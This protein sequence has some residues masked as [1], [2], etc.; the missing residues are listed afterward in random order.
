MFEILT[1]QQIAEEFAA[2]INGSEIGKELTNDLEKEAKNLGLVVIFG[3]SDDLAELRGA[4]NDEVSVYDG[5]TIYFDENG[6]LESECEDETCPHEVRRQESAK[7]VEALWCEGDIS[8]TY[9]TEIPHAKFNVLED[10]E[11]YCTG[12]VFHIEDLKNE[13]EHDPR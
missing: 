11:I 5:G 2:K 9:K 6:L 7:S 13:I 10:D 8:W 1:M 12:I 3:A 4:I